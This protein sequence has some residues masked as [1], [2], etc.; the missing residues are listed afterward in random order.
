MGIGRDGRITA[1][2]NR[3]FQ[4]AFRPLL[5]EVCA[6]L[7]PAAEPLIHSL[8]VYGSVAEARAVPGRSDLDLSLIFGAA[9]SAAGRRRLEA[10][11]RQIEAAHPV[12]SKV[13]FD[14][15]TLAELRSAEQ[16]L[17]WR[18]WLRHHCRCLCGPDPAE[19]IPL[20]RPSRA[21]ALAVKGD[22]E[23]VLGGYRSALE[24]APPGA[25]ARR[26]MREAARKLIRSTNVLRREDDRD[27]PDTLEDHAEKLA[28]RHPGQGAALR[29]FL[30]EA[31]DPGDDPADFAERLGAFTAWM[32]QELQRS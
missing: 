9:P 25:P 23:R 6:R 1:V 31:R 20:F 32:A 28:R 22:F 11:R 14:I 19:D 21:L 10:L 4:E 13:D 16:G 2:G 26:L 17:A 3:P 30:R 15:G 24:A 8:H 7:S 27:W 18:Y 29:A 12:A 5:E